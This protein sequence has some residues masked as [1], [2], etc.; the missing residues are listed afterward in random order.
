MASLPLS[1]SFASALVICAKRTREGVVAVAEQ[2]AGEP[3]LDPDIDRDR[4]GERGFE[5]RRHGFDRRLEAGGRAG[6][7]GAIGEVEFH[8]SCRAPRAPT[9]N[10]A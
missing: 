10:L 5:E 7:V 4:I 6:D 9:G 8:R 3:A 2:A 1:G